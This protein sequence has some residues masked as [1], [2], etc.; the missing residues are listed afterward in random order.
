MSEMAIFARILFW[1]DGEFARRRISRD[2]IICEIVE[3]ARWH[4][5]QEGGI[6]E[7][8]EF[9]QWRNLRDGVHEIT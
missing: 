6:R 1:L 8:A 5:L 3:F 4:N 9:A 7:K 2:N